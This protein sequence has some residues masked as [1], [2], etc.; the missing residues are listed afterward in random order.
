MA[1]V[2]PDCILEHA[3]HDFVAADSTA[4]FEVK[5]LV[6]QTQRLCKK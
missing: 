5:Q 2:C 6:R 4:S 3:K 1:G